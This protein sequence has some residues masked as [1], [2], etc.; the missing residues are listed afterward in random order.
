MLDRI[1]K[2]RVLTHTIFWIVML[3]LQSQIFLYTGYPLNVIFVY[4]LA[5]LPSI[6]I[7]AYFLV[8]YQIPQ[9]VYKK[10]YLKFAGSLLLSAYIVTVLA[11]LLTV[12]VAEPFIG[13]V[14]DVSNIDMF[15][16]VI[17]SVDRLARNYLLPV[18][19]V[20][21]I[22]ASIKLIKKQNEE[23]RRLE[24]LEKQKTEAELNFLKAQIHPHFLLNTLNN[25]YALALKNSNK[26]AESILKLSEMLTYVLY[27]CNEKFV[28]L[29][30]EI[31]L[32]EN[33]IAL[34]KLR[35]GEDLELIFKKDVMEK[36]IQ[37]APLILLSIVENA[38]KHGVSSSLEKP[39]VNI[40]LHASNDLLN[41]KVFNTKSTTSQEDLTEYTK[42][43]GSSN[44]KKQLKL[45]YPNNH[46]I[47]VKEEDI[48]YEVQLQININ[49]A[50]S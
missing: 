14:D 2:N 48:S 9:F 23:K 33:Y 45:L 5:I 50:F 42:G 25:I 20:P 32:L 13:V 43:I 37:I 40:L 38:F 35:Y 12:F 30:D 49:N 39:I 31:R 46:K 6:I 18:Y 16:L 22:M 28:S 15:L 4:T 21:F 36:N 27:K 19:I 11:R 7:A 26:S 24:E 34:E 3:T 29:E 44:I 8:Y 41:F 10:K 47:E 17:F 1:L